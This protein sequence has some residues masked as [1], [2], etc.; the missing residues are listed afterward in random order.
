MSYLRRT[1]NARL[2][3]AVV[4]VS[5]LAPVVRA[6]A[7]QFEKSLPQ[8]CVVF[9]NLDDFSGLK[10]RMAETSFAKLCGDPAMKPFVEGIAGEFGKLLG[11]AQ[12]ATGVDFK[13]LLSLPTG[14]IAFAIQL[15]QQNPDE[16]PF[17]YFVAD[18]AGKED[19]VRSLL[20]RLEPKLEQAGMTKRSV[21]GLTAFGRG[22]SKP[23]EE[24]CY[25]VQGSALVIG[26]DPEALGK[27]AGGLKGGSATSLANNERLTAFRQRAGGTGDFELFVDVSTIVAVAA[28]KGGQQAG[29][30]IAMLGLNAF[31]S[32]G[33]TLSIGKGEFEG[34]FQLLINTRGQS[35]LLNFFNMPAK[36][37]RPE[38]W[39]PS[40]VASYNS[41]N[42]D[43]DL[44]Y[45]T[46]SN[47]VNG[48]APGALAQAD[49]AASMLGG[50]PN[51]PL[52]RSIKEDVIGPLG[53]RLSLVTDLTE[54][55]GIPTQRILLAW[56]LDS[57]E[58][59]ARIVDQLAG[60]FGPA[61]GGEKKSVAG[62]TVHVF[63]VPIQVPGIPPMRIGLTVTKRHLMVASH[64]ELLDKALAGGGKAGLAESDDFRRIASKFPAQLSG[65]SYN[66]GEASAGAFWRFMKSGQFDNVLQ[67]ALQDDGARAALGGLVDAI[68]GEKLPDF[69]TV[70]KYFKSSG[71]YV[72]MDDQGMRFVSFSVK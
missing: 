58:K 59:I 22:E 62:N 44:F 41:F 20:S 25:G 27:V 67:M 28:A 64:V 5:A 70:R 37:L 16:P 52:I 8:D 49:A 17:I 6:A 47:L 38:E 43:V 63:P 71:G 69:D 26:N 19:R 39:V 42:W 66:R 4:A 10:N 14:Q 56:E 9:V 35:Q 12:E 57:S 21:G 11:M 50:D 68:K 24:L 53:N 13:E 48:Y 54:A 34:Q 23:R 40:D 36:P 29:A 1:I 72:V 31:Q 30:G 55:G 51:N 18:V 60:M 45:N 15:H 46:L 2:W 3:L 33:L 7:G 32:A 61:I 65:I